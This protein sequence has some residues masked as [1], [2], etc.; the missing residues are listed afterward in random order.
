MVNCDTHQ[1]CKCDSGYKGESC[2][3]PVIHTEK[4]YTGFSPDLGTWVYYAFEADQD[5][6]TIEWVVTATDSD[7]N[8]CE[9][10]TQATGSWNYYHLDPQTD[11]RLMITLKRTTDD[12]ALGLYI[13]DG[14]YPT[15]WNYTF[16]N[17]SVNTEITL[18]LEQPVGHKWY[19]GIF[20]WGAANYSLK[21]TETSKCPCV[22]SHH[23]SC[24]ENE[25]DVCI[26]NEPYVGED[27]GSEPKDLTSGIAVMDEMVEKGRWNYYT[28][29]VV[30][31]SAAALTVKE[32]NA[33]GVAW[34]FIG[35]NGFPTETD[36][37]YSDKNHH[38]S[39]HQLSYS[40]KRQETGVLYIGVYGSP[41]ITEISGKSTVHYDIVCW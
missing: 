32:H 2:T 17:V 7:K 31:K 3:I 37:M 8:K 35:F 6:E 26:C 4:Q 1:E 13:M 15:L 5:Y 9:L 34:V 38:N 41:Y 10:F 19:F 24:K 40:T 22:D 23:G 25:E 14:N 21:V 33:A 20:G 39:T 11:N 28:I 12:G 29:S 16:S 36:Y 27:C 18:S 30:D